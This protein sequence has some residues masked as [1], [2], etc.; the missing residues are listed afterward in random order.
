MHKIVQY[1]EVRKY[2]VN[3][4][5]LKD[6][7]KTRKKAQGLSIEQIAQALGVKKTTAE[8][9][10]RSDSCFSIPERETWPRLKELLGITTTEHDAAITE[11]I[12]KENEFDTSNRVYD[13]EG[14]APTLT[15]D[16]EA[17]AKKI[18]IKMY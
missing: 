3:I 2:P 13:V 4:E 9:W 16:T 5:K 18:I 15:C 10:F 8:H 17:T 6:L 1:V 7:L 11:F 14:I 12:I